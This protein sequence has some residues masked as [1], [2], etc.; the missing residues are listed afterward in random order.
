MSTAELSPRRRRRRYLVGYDEEE[1]AV[2]PEPEEDI[3][4]GVPGVCF[5]FYDVGKVGVLGG[6]DT[7]VCSVATCQHVKVWVLGILSGVHV[8][9]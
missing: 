6:G 8:I 1:L 4:V 2:K 7:E 5:G 3:K 9:S